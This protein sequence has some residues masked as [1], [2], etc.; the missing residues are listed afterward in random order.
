MYQEERMELILEYLK[1]H[2]RINVE[3][4]CNLYGVSRDTARRDLVKLEKQGAILRTH[5]GALLKTLQKDFKNYKDRLL[6]SS[7]EKKEIG[8]VAASLIKNGEKIMMDTS[9]TVQFCAEFLEVE[10]CSIIT[11]SINVAH[12]LSD[13][14][15]VKIHL[16]G[17]QL[18]Q[19]HCY[20]YGPSTIEILSNYYAHKA[21]IGTGGITE[22]GLTVVEEEDGYVTK[23]MIEQAEEVILLADHSKFGKNGFFKFADLSQIDSIITDKMP[24]KEFVKACKAYEINII[25]TK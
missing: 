12:L 19:K 18:H 13:K 14:S 23:K 1:K 16:L 10:N 24:D 25:L 3:T 2:K 22:K 4:I 11:N 17:G 7:K 15:E 9:T 8:K 6:D 5:G 20:L 21:F